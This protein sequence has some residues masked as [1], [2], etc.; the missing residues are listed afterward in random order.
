M[1]GG[2]P[3]SYL[4]SGLLVALASGQAHGYDLLEKAR[5]L[6]ISVPDPGG[7]YRM[8]RSME[9]DGDVRSWWEP[10]DVGPLR[11]TYVLTDKGIVSLVEAASSLRTTVSQLQGLLKAADAQAA[12][13]QVAVTQVAVT[14]GLAPR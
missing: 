12:V 14:Q 10:S 8:L 6:G 1:S 7:L 11:R 3:R 2:L 5:G 13:T 4:R 9:H